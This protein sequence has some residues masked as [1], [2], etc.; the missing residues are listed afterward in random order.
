MKTSNLGQSF[1]KQFEG[2][3]LKSY[4]DSGGV[5]TI[6][7]GHT[8]GVSKDQE[9]DIETAEM[10][11]N[12]DLRPIEEILSKELPALLQTEFNALVSFI[13]NVGIKAFR[14]SSLFKD[15]YSGDSVAAAKEFLRW[16]KITDKKGNKVVLPGLM[17][18]RKAESELYLHGIY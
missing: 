17:T 16:N 13:F 4:K 2:L 7:W 8:K 12:E 18:R 15:V 6:G 1:I 3:R 5:W 14:K 11:F 9:I 10:F